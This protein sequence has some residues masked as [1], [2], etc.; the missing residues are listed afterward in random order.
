VHP[1][2]QLSYLDS[3]AW[4]VDGQG[5]GDAW[6]GEEGGEGD[7]SGG[8]RGGGWVQVEPLHLGGFVGWGDWTQGRRREE[9]ED[10]RKEGEGEARGVEGGGAEREREWEE[11]LCGGWVGGKS[12]SGAQV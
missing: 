5:G 6:V 12:P 10:V 7:A 9:D 11:L 1:F 8:V 4:V 3:D 2:H